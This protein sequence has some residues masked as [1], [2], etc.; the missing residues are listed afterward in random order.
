MAK[1]KKSDDLQSILRNLQQHVKTENAKFNLSKLPSII[2]FVEN[3]EWL[4]MKHYAQP[5]KL[6]PMQLVLLKCFYRGS[7]G[8]EDLALTEDEIQLIKESGLTTDES[9]DVL[10]KWAEGEIFREL[11]L[12]WG[13]R[14]LSED[15][16]IFDPTQGR[17]TRLGELWNNGETDVVSLSYDENEERMRIM[18]D[19]ELLSNGVRPVFR[20]RTRSGHEIEATDNHP[21]LT[22]EG[23][24]EVKDLKEGNLVAIAPKVPFFGDRKDLSE[25]EAALLGYMSSQS[26]FS[27]GGHVGIATDD[28][29][30]VND[31]FQK[32]QELYG[33]NVEMGKA[34]EYSVSAASMSKKPFS[35]VC[36]Q[37]CK[38]PSATS[39]KQA[40]KNCN[41]L[42]CL[43]L[44]NGLKD[45]DS[46]HK[47]VPVR[48]DQAPREIIES[49]LRALFS[50]DGSII[51]NRDQ[52]SIEMYV[53]N[54][55]MVL[56]LQRLL[57]RFT[58]F[59]SFVPEGNGFRL[60]MTRRHDVKM[61]LD[62][63]GF[64]NKTEQILRFRKIHQKV[65][66]EE[67][68]IFVPV[69]SIVAI[70]EKQTFDIAVSHKP[71]LQNFVSDGFVVHNSGKGFITSVI[72]LYEAMKLLEAPG[73]N[74]Y[75]QYEL[76]TAAPFLI[77]TIANSAE[78]AKHLF[79]EIRD[80]IMLSEYFKDRLD[81]EHLTNDS[82]VFLTPHDINQNEDLAKRGLPPREGSVRIVSGHSNSD[83][84]VGMSCYCLLLDEIGL[85]KNTA[86]SS[87]GD[88]IYN[89]LAPA[90]KTYI[91]KQ[92][93]FDTRTG[94]PKLDD[95]GEPVTKDVF[96]GKI[97]CI[98]SPRGKEG[99]FFDLYSHAHEVSHRL[100]MRLPTWKVN[101]Q[102]TEAALRADFPNMPE[103]KF[104]MEFGAEFSGTGGESFFPRDAVE[105]CFERRGLK[106]INMGKPGIVYFAHL[107]PALSSHNYGMVVCHKE[108]YLNQETKQ[109]DF[110]IVID[111]VKHWAPTPDKLISV[112]D[113]DSYIMALNRRFHFGLVSYD[114][115]NS[116]QSIQKLRRIGMPAIETRFSR[117]YKMMI[118]DNLYELV[119]SGRLLIPDHTASHNLLKLEMINLQKKYL[120]TGGYRVLPKADGDILTDDLCDA[121]AGACFNAMDRTTRKLPQG[122]LVNTP[123]STQQQVFRQMQGPIPDQQLSNMSPG[124][125]R[126]VDHTR[127]QGPDSNIVP[128]NPNQWRP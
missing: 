72:A 94:E 14:C 62:H 25:K 15:A 100:M 85:Y 34:S 54:R 52:F 66:V 118:Y 61:F 108:V 38:E 98:S 67:D 31:F 116:Q 26:F 99:I 23:W 96:D 105:A 91:R 95:N 18:T 24:K 103:E 77:L 28:I 43:F 7:P 107:D 40:V 114:Q 93:I 13:R 39:T 68:L 35:Y 50:A 78:Q 79:K 53:G 123:V 127:G 11:I 4:G 80:K 46:E 3:K 6:R 92:P 8:N 71:H 110:R 70:G 16:T 49:Y 47:F 122:K 112:N 5:V 55:D 90:V 10:A 124:L 51:E 88:Q 48:I 19:C 73:G 102:M 20:L 17:T 126:W 69:D 121:L 86:G 120:A 37:N 59:S 45:K 128:R 21:M 41:N 57:Q 30:A 29:D 89:S 97:I 75:A 60:S 32:A 58:I 42:P 74:P 83:S 81:D 2:E 115:W 119:A 56:Q 104:R 27:A 1:K 36:L 33:N 106:D 63:I 22:N 109:R 113:V 44:I 125:R 111:H 65:P 9:G 84:L 87:S 12:V 117:N 101:P 64:V 82:L 76:A